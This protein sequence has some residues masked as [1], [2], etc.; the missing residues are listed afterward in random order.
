MKC[1][2][3][4]DWTVGFSQCLF[5]W[6][7]LIAGL[8]AVLVGVATV[9]F[10]H[11]QIKQADRISSQ[12]RTSREAVARAKLPMAS[13]EV[14]AIAKRWVTAL[15]AVAPVVV[16]RGSAISEAV[17]IEPLP[18]IVTGAFDELVAAT[19]D[20][21]ALFAVSAIYSEYQV[22][23]ARSEDIHRNPRSHR[24]ALSSYYLQAVIVH[25]LALELLLYG[26]RENHCVGEVS[27]SDLEASAQQILITA[28]P[29]E[30]V[31]AV[32]EERASKHTKIP[33]AL[34]REG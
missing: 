1:G 10:L 20:H 21:R 24:L 34:G 23:R 27:W 18:S 30:Q 16:A 13:S 31:L 7:T 15:D 5:D 8:L 4:S 3:P 29:R 28:Q 9:I 12:I 2:L 17:H 32:I 6:Q 11:R 33:F 25:A 14:A 22:L 19:S 26:R